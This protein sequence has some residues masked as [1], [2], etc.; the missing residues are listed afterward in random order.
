MLPAV[1]QP[2]STFGRGYA[3]GLAGALSYLLGRHRR[4]WRRAMAEDA[5][6]DPHYIPVSVERSKR[7]FDIVCGLAAFLV[8]CVL[9]VPL[10]IAIKLSSPGPVFYRQMRVGRIT[11]RF[12]GLFWL[13]KFRT[14]RQDAEAKSG[15][16]WASDND[17]RI[18]A[19]GRFMRKT[20]LDEIPQCIN[21][22]RGEM[23]IVGP[24]P[25]RPSFF[26]RLESEI[27][28]YIERTYGLR[29]GITGLAQINQAYD[30]N[31]EDVRNKVLYDHTYAL[32]LSRWKDW[33][34]SDLGIIVR[35]AAVVVTGRGAK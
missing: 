14:M 18:T 24:R 20:R 7:L 2:L 6:R 25:E 28:F 11:P 13:I 16:V 34:I 26:R 32:R 12:T 33:L 19:L 30:Q 9:Y 27:P 8:L 3:A 31:I 15:P 1:L 5:G 21:V 10:A 29:P 22:L 4:P 23:S 35:T 17:P